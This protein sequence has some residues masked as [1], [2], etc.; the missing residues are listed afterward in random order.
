MRERFHLDAPGW[1]ENA[2]PV[3]HLAPVAEAVWRQRRAHVR[4]R[5][6]KGEV[7]CYLDPLGIVLKGG[8]WYLVARLPSSPSTRTGSPGSSSST[9]SMS[10]SSDPTA[11]SWLLPASS[12][13]EG[14]ESAIYASRAAFDF[15]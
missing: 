2:E 3:P 6:W 5:R 9:P 4:Y 7:Q 13:S 11:S 10:T 8:L 14:H 15:L 12:G 1:F